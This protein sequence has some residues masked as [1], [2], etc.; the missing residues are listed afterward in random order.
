MCYWILTDDTNRLIV[1]GTVRSTERTSRPNLQLPPIE[2]VAVQKGEEDDTEG[3][4]ELDSA[5]NFPLQHSG[6]LNYLNTE[7]L[8]NMQ[9]DNP[10]NVMLKVDLDEPEETMVEEAE[11]TRKYS[12]DLTEYNRALDRNDENTIEEIEGADT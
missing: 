1:R 6:E 7:E 11:D 8:L 10:T 2:E 9:V 5:Q 12:D 3:D 4:H